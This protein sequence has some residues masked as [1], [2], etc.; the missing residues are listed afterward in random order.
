MGQSQEKNLHHQNGNTSP[1]SSQA[2]EASSTKDAKNGIFYT[3]KAA[4]AYA[5]KHGTTQVI[6]KNSSS[7]VNPNVKTPYSPSSS[8][9]SDSNPITFPIANITNKEYPLFNNTSSK[10]ASMDNG[11]SLEV[12]GI[13]IQYSDIPGHP[14][15]VTDNAKTINIQPVALLSS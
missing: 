3:Q 9:S 2:S 11:N 15:N 12:D 4:D 7:S 5:A 13:L 1:S 14:N 8:S 6:A 10:K